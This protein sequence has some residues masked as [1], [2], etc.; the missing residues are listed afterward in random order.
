MTQLVKAKEAIDR[1][2]REDQLRAVVVEFNRRDRDRKDRLKL[3]GIRDEKEIEIAGFGLNNTTWS[4]EQKNL[5]VV[6]D[7][8][9]TNKFKY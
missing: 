8:M 9:T 4:K 1:Q 7:E 5:E 2:A 6:K 3:Y